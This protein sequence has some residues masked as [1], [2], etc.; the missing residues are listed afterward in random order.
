MAIGPSSRSRCCRAASTPRDWRTCPCFPRAERSSTSTDRTGNSSTRRTSPTEQKTKIIGA[1]QHAT[2]S[3]GFAPDKVWG[4]T[5]E[6]R[7][8]QIT[9]SALGQEAPLEEKKGWDPD[10][11]K[12]KKMSTLLDDLIPEFSVRLGASGLRAAVRLAH[13]DRARRERRSERARARLL[14]DSGRLSRRC[15]RARRGL[16]PLARRTNCLR[17]PAES[18]YRPH[19][20][21]R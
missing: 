3:L 13:R 21:Q 18:L 19:P 14:F 7:G 15:R 1:L 2:E 9:Y 11:A 4:A 10:F 8:T 17:L 12:R 16:D 6:D 5:I 20:A